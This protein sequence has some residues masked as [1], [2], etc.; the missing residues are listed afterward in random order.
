MAVKVRTRHFSGS[1]QY[2]CY[3]GISATNDEALYKEF[4]ADLS[5]DFELSDQGKLDW[6]LSVSV[7]QD[8][9]NKRTVLSQE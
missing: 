1:T 9:A 2:L 7:K 3:D 8:L 4:L 6:Y 5:K